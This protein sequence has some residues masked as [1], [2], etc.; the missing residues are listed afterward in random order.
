MSTEVQIHIADQ[1]DF[2][3]AE[4]LKAL[5]RLSSTSRHFRKV[6]HDKIRVTK[7]FRKHLP[8]K[9][10]LLDN[11]EWATFAQAVSLVTYQHDCYE[12]FSYL[13][14]TFNEYADFIA[15]PLEGWKNIFDIG[16]LLYAKVWNLKNAL[17]PDLEMFHS[18]TPIQKLILMYCA[19]MI[20]YAWTIQTE[21]ANIIGSLDKDN[22]AMCLYSLRQSFFT[23]GP[24]AM[25]KLC[26]SERTP[27]DIVLDTIR[28]AE[29]C[30]DCYFGKAGK[31]TDLM[32]VLECELEKNIYVWTDEFVDG[33]LTPFVEVGID[34]VGAE[35]LRECLE[36]WSDGSLE[37][38]WYPV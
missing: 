11:M 14:Q 23:E 3:N 21:F 31:G 35:T 10:E 27:R 12:V 32:T 16:L 34:R 20:Q 37:F 7:A 24:Q 25:R 18:F 17:L 29:Y 2:S 19:L 6:V 26:Q 8:L 28:R 30:Y 38:P 36:W 1:F 33:D 13:E 4:D 22:Q 9:P 5:L 15:L